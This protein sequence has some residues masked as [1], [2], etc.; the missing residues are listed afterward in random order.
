MKEIKKT[1]EVLKKA[2]QVARE[3]FKSLAPECFF[4]PQYPQNFIFD[5]IIGSKNYGKIAIKIKKGAEITE[6]TGDKTALKKLEEIG[7]KQ[8]D[9]AF[10]RS[11]SNG[12]KNFISY[13]FKDCLELIVALL[14]E[15][16]QKSKAF[17]DFHKFVYKVY[18]PLDKE[19]FYKKTGIFITD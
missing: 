3:Y 17:D 15:D 11:L 8:A 12:A 16:F 1:D 5:L 18:Y 7:N 2:S 13:P 4:T 19:Q 6:L 14:H 10:Y 9:K